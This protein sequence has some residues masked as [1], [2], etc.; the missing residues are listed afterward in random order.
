MAGVRRR[1]AVASRGQRGAV[2]PPP[3]GRRAGLQVRVLGLRRAARPARPARVVQRRRRHLLLGRATPGTRGLRAQF[4]QVDALWLSRR[5]SPR[6]AG[7]RGAPLPGGRAVPRPQA[8]LAAHPPTVLPAYRTPIRRPAADV[9]SRA[10]L[11]ALVAVM[12]VLGVLTPGVLDV[13]WVREVRTTAL[14]VLVSTSVAAVVW[15]VADRLVRR[16]RRTAG[17]HGAAGR[18]RGR[19]VGAR[20]VPGL[21]VA[22][23]AAR[24]ADAW[25]SCR[26]WPTARCASCPTPPRPAAPAERGSGRQASSARRR[27]HWRATSSTSPR[28]RRRSACRRRSS[29]P[30]SSSRPS[31]A[32]SCAARRT[33]P[34]RT[35]RRSRGT[36]PASCRSGARAGSA[37]AAPGRARRRPGSAR[38]ARASATPRPRSGAGCGW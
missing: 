6:A 4:A 27:R 34:R 16:L 9:V 36:R 31:S 7:R 22:G 21:G 33:S 1:P 37:A 19:R 12:V 32:V 15:W 29:S 23:R 26:T 10:F 35:C 5:V 11:R 3:A 30:I 20:P 14:H 24:A 13:D 28:V 25:C 8:M 17:R 38:T 18:R 2:P